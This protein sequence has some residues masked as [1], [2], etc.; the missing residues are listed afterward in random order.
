[1]DPKLTRARAV[2]KPYRLERSPEFFI[3]DATMSGE[4]LRIAE[5]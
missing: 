1:M 5:S 2:M 4:V 3:A